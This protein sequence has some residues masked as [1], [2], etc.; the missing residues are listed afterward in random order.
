MNQTLSS[1][2]SHFMTH[3]QVDLWNWQQDDPLELTPKLIDMI[4]GAF[5]K[6]LSVTSLKGKFHLISC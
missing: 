3:F 1:Q 2:L 4:K 5:C 6:I